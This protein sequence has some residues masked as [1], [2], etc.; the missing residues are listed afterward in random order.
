MVMSSALIGAISLIILSLLATSV[1][2]WVPPL[3]A[4]DTDPGEEQ[5]KQE[6]QEQYAVYALKAIITVEAAVY[7][8]TN[9][10]LLYSWVSSPYGLVTRKP[11]KRVVS[12][13]P[14]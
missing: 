5:L 3:G 9:T 2:T 11:R 12:S 4:S 13:P 7:L 14:Q 8:A 6:A 10:K 1:L